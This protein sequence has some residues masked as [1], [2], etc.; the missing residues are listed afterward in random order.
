MTVLKPTA[1][2]LY[3]Q[4]K[5][6]LVH[7]VL[8]GEWKPGQLLPSEFKL[9]DE[10]GLSQGTVRKAIEDMASEGLV[11]RQ[12]GK[13]TFVT[14][15]DG[16]YHPF[17]FHRFYSDQGERIA[18]DEAV[19]VSSSPAKADTRIAKGLDIRKGTAGCKTVRI[20][21]LHAEP[22]LVETFFL[23]DS[24][25]PGARDF[26]EQE[27]PKSVYLFMERHYNLLITKVLEQLRARSATE[28]EAELLNL[29]PGTPV[30]EVERIAYSLGGEA[31]EWRTIVGATDH[32]HYR[33]ELG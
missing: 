18:K 27:N 7:R 11:T 4:V 31:V 15:H 16:D 28:Q 12:A 24:I 32:I 2:P 9:A 13:G 33:N 19:L 22:A 25:C 20:R 21:Q 10:Y 30:L 5:Q 1:Q 26:L 29:E 3:Q 23:I 14:T 6:H 17:R 8:T